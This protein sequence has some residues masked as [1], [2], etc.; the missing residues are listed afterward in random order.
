MEPD[1]VPKTLGEGLAQE[2][3][4]RLLFAELS[5]D[6]GLPVYVPTVDVCPV[7]AAKPFLYL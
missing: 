5:R 4:G 1:V 7:E 2:I 6:A 3:Y